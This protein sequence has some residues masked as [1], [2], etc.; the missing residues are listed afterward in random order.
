MHPARAR[1]RNYLTRN[2]RPLRRGANERLRRPRDFAWHHASGD[3]NVARRDAIL[4]TARSFRCPRAL[5]ATVSTRDVREDLTVSRSMMY[6]AHRTVA[7]SLN[8]EYV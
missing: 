4:I 2:S 6:R 8:E 5:V 3:E 7:I 1:T